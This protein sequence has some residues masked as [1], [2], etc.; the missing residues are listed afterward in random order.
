MRMD[1]IPPLVLIS[2]VLV[3]VF[4]LFT[5]E[6]RLRKISRSMGDI[7]LDCDKINFR[8]FVNEKRWKH[9]QEKKIG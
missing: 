3:L 6:S 9:M 1:K 8:L 2:S 4:Y 7:R 5:V